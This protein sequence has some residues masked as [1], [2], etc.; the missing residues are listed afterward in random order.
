MSLRKSLKK[1]Q[2]IKPT[3]LPVIRQTIYIVT[4]VG[5]LFGCLFGSGAKV[6]NVQSG[7]KTAK[8]VKKNEKKKL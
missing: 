8:K 5:F 7:S 3:A 2:K 6:I 1:Y 4:E